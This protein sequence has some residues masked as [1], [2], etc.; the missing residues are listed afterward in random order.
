MVQIFMA[1][2]TF[3]RSRHLSVAN[4]SHQVIASTGH[5]LSRVLAL[6]LFKYLLILVLPPILVTLLVPNSL[7]I[8][9]KS[10]CCCLPIWKEREHCCHNLWSGSGQRLALQWLSG[11]IDGSSI[12]RVAYNGTSCLRYR[13]TLA[14][15]TVDDSITRVAHNGTSCQR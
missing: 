15:D 3:I 2:I 9:I 12:T 8:V 5:L 7:G 4:R 11:K 1:A 10:C 6:M 13:I 14:Y